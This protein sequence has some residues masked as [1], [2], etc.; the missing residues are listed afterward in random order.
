MLGDL[1]CLSSAQAYLT[2][3]H[4]RI[5]GGQQLSVT[6]SLVPQ[7]PEASDSSPAVSLMLDLW[8]STRPSGPYPPCVA[9]REF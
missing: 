4:K 9:T 2:C 5:G 7:T 6:V 8:R 3:G 1:S